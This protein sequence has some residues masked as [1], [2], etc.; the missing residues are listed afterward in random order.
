[1]IYP[2]IEYSAT[3]KP[4]DEYILLQVQTF[5]TENE[6]I[7]KAFDGYD[8]AAIFTDKKIIFISIP[9]NSMAASIQYEIEVLPYRSIFRYS[10]LGLSNAKH[11]KLELTVFGATLTF[12]IPKYSDAVTLSKKIE[13]YIL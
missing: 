4:L 3:T 2:R 1:M 10:V 11:G 6:K 5:L 12:Y 13:Q 9:Q 8:V 7:I